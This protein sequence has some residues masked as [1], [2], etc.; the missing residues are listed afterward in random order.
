MDWKQELLKRLDALADKLGTTGAYLWQ[1]LVKQ[2]IVTGVQDCLIG[3]TWLIFWIVALKLGKHLRESGT[4][5][6][7]AGWVLTIG[8]NGMWI[9]IGIYLYSGI[10]ELLNPEY[11]A[12][13][14][15]L[16]T[17]GK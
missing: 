15:I 3:L 11:F 12:L 1:V 10:A 13:T 7:D 14:Q 2:G 4:E 16:Q 8:C 17:L 6:Q 9:V 5:N